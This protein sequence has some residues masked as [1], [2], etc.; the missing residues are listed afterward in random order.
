MF[1]RIFYSGLPLPELSIEETSPEKLTD[2]LNT[3]SAIA[4]AN[5][6]TIILPM[7]WYTDK[8]KFNIA[9]VIDNTGK[10]LGYQAKNQLDPSED[11]LW[12]P[13]TDRHIFEVDGLKFGIVICHEG[14]RYPETVRWAAR[15]DAAIVFHPHCSGSDVSGTELTEFRDKNNPYYEQAT[16]MRALENTIYFASSNYTSRFSESASCIIAPDGS[17]LANQPYGKVGVIVVDIDSAKATALLANRFK[18]EALDAV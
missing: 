1:P 2:A 3:A 18:H 7:D 6:I 13:G 11:T 16:M 15:R 17:C 8:G 9:H 14:F 4:A 5:N 12:L 10:V